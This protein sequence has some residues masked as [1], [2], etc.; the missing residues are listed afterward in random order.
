MSKTIISIGSVINH[1][2]VHDKDVTGRV[3]LILENTVIVR[4]SDGDTH[5]VTKEILEDDGFSVDE[6]TY[7]YQNHFTRS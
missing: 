6:K 5:L 7:V 2:T 1:P 4:D 3:E